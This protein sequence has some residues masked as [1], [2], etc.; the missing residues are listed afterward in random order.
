MSLKSVL[1]ILETSCL[2]EVKEVY[3][4]CEVFLFFLFFLTGV[5]VFMLL[6]V[7]EFC[8]SVISKD[9][10][11]QLDLLMLDTLYKVSESQHLPLPPILQ[12]SLS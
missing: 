10:G 12:L 2:F 5:C 8:F 7:T 11:G 9:G 1:R 4:E 3:T 6:L